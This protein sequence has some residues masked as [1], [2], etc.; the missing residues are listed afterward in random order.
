MKNIVNVFA[1][2]LTISVTFAQNK[3]ATA[4]KNESKNYTYKANTAVKDSS[5]ADAEAEYRKAISKDG[6]NVAAKYNLG[7]VYYENESY[8]EAFNR[9]KQA[10][11][12]ATTKADKHKAYHNMGNVF[13]NNKEYEKAV[14]AYKKALRNNPSDDETR[15]N[16]ALAKDMLEKNPPQDDDKDKK[17][18]DQK[19]QEKEQDKKDQ[20]KNDQK[21]KNEDKGD[22]EKDEGG[23]DDKNK[24][25]KGDEEKEKQQKDNKEGDGKA[26]QKDDKKQQEKQQPKP[27]QLSPQQV[28]S[29]LQAMNNAEK[30]TQDKLNEKKAKGVKVK[31]EKDW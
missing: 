19:E 28:K 14:A 5:Y 3:D 9:Y 30:K 16:F 29:L 31:A 7:N 20:D 6:E 21:D 26:D 2:L 11:E 13:M 10:A 4:F 1:M 18:K 23:K 27:N 22:K 17:D 25:G 24:D 8:E 15:Y 12:V